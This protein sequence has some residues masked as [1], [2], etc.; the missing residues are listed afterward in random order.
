MEDN[1]LSCVSKFRN[2]N[3]FFSCED[4]HEPTLSITTK[5]LSQDEDKNIGFV[6]LLCCCRSPLS[7][8]APGVD[9]SLVRETSEK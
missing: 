1:R 5:F 4:S 3:L 8:E 7:A 6:F 9:E 2:I